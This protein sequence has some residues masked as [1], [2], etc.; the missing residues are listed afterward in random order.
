MRSSALRVIGRETMEAAVG[1]LSGAPARANIATV[2]LAD[3]TARIAWAMPPYG[4][5]CKAAA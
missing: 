1:R 5:N 3:G 4:Q 2:S